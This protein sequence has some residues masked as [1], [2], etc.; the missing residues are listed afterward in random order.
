[1]EKGG[2]LVPKNAFQ[3]FNSQIDIESSQSISELE[4]L[5]KWSF[6]EALSDSSTC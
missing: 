2:V 6:A 3:L 1:M 5:K 4:S